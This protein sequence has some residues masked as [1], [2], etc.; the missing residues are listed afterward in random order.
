MRVMAIVMN[1]PSTGTATASTHHI[2]GATLMPMMMPPIHMIGAM[3]T[4]LTLIT[5]SICTC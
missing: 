3:I 1:R 4:R 5:A 2:P